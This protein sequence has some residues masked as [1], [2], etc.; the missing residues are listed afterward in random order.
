[1]SFEAGSKPPLH[2]LLARSSALASR[3]RRLEKLTKSAEGVRARVAAVR[4]LDPAVDQRRSTNVSDGKGLAC[5]GGWSLEV[6]AWSLQLRP[7]LITLRRWRSPTTL[8]C[9]GRARQAGKDGC[10]PN[11]TNIA[12]WKRM[13]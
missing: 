2:G 10:R 6:A 8:A 13:A 7:T 4:D 12:A 3:M 9:Q 1:M 11:T 5:S